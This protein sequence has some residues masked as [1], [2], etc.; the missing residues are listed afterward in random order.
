ML[1][2]LEIYHIW[3]YKDSRQWPAFFSTTGY[4]TLAP[5]GVCLSPLLH[6]WQGEETR[7]I[8]HFFSLNPLG[9]CVCISP[10]GSCTKCTH[11]GRTYYSSPIREMSQGS[12]SVQYMETW[13]V[14]AQSLYEVAIFPNYKT[15]RIL[16]KKRVCTLKKNIHP[17]ISL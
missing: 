6:M 15:A 9:Y 5:W 8:L 17:V 2:P 13:K 11:I 16:F 14:N 1:S 3:R 10:A 7:V 12:P 4:F